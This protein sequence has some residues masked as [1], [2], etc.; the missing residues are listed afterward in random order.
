MTYPTVPTPLGFASLLRV[1][2]WTL[3]LAVLT[4][5]ASAA[6][7]I[8][9]FW[10]IYRITVELFSARP[11]MNA[12]WPLAWWALGLLALR[13]AL[14]AVSH[15]LAHMGA[16][17]IQHRLRLAMARRLGEVPLSFFAGR[18]SGGLRRTLTDDVNSLEGFFAHMLPDA[19]AAAA[20]P[21]AALAL[22]FAA[23]WRLALAALAPLPV[24]VVAQGWLMRRSAERMR[25]WAALQK[26]IANQVGEYVRGVHVVKSFG[27]DARSFGELAAAVR[28]AVDWVA[29]Y[30]RVSVAGWALFVGLLTANLVVVAPLGAWLHACGS[31]DVPTWLLFLLVAPAVLAPLLRLT[32][33]LGEQM[34]RA[35]ALAR[36]NEVLAAPALV[37]SGTARVPE[38]ALDIAFDGVR[39]RYGERLALDGVGFTA[40]AGQVTALVGPS[41]SGKSTLVRLVARLYE[42]E[43][44]SLRVGGVDVR[45]WPLDALLA[46]VGI[47][48]QEVVLFHGSVR[49]NLRLARPDA[50][51]AEV[52][53]AARAAQAHDFIAALPQ[54]YD[55]PLGERGARLS[56]GERQRLSIARALLKDAPIL[57][58]D[59][60]TA[61]VDAENEA[62]IQQALDRLC[63]GRTVLVVGHRLRTMRHA[64]RIVVMDGGRVAGQG[65]HDELL[66]DCETYRRLWRDHEQAREWTLGSRA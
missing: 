53:A 56:G 51:D 12:V 27:L 29:G 4:A 59:E 14:M 20:V 54:G 16:F 42:F 52:E 28:G 26:R 18:G 38:G 58:L 57:L 43:C 62:L 65:T 41:G 21:L 13:W 35:T 24:A 3:T 30:A 55:T 49:D 9:P 47:V 32:F 63:Q 64:D 8:A 37:E 48:F 60:A 33:A 66:R 10:F 34:Q 45:E 15:A 25:E 1:A 23:D 44:G 46:R 11:D 7:S 61:S 31:L 40:R 50:S 5:I 36:I 19:V 22:L 17:A 39:H 6:L 2:P